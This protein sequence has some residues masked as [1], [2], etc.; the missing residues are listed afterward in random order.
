MGSSAERTAPP[1]DPTICII[2]RRC[3]PRLGYAYLDQLLHAALYVSPTLMTRR[4]VDIEAGV[5]QPHK[6]ER[7]HKADGA[8]AEICR[9][10]NYSHVEG[11]PHQGKGVQ[12]CGRDVRHE[13]EAG[14][15]KEI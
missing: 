8:E 12:G 10:G 1:L 6:R 9:I 14:V 4:P 15:A 13:K 2:F 5:R 7:C 3:T 11:V